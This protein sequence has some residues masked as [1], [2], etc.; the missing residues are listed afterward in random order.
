[1]SIYKQQVSFKSILKQKE[2]EGLPLLGKYSEEAQEN[3]SESLD[4]P[5]CMDMHN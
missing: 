3:N 2:Q 1:L 5:E 4:I